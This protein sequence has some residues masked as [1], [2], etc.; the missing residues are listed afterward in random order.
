MIKFI[1]LQEMIKSY[2]LDAKV[3]NFKDTIE[4]DVNGY[5]W[6]LSFYDL[7]TPKC[8]IAHT[9]FIFK[10]DE[11][12][13]NIRKNDFLYLKDLNCVYKIIK[14]EDISNLELIINKI[15][16]ENMFGN[17]IV[18]LSKFL[19]EPE[20]LV[21]NILYDKKIKDK[22]LFTCEYLPNSVVIPCQKLEFN[23]KLNIDGKEEIDML[24]KKENKND[25]EF[26]FDNKYIY[27]QNSISDIANI[28]AEF[29]IKH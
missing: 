15:L 23:F 29:I 8:L 22:S 12:K 20:T 6:V 9:R 11:N 28:V 16:V 13:E 21:N 2:F 5:N 25:F 18:E 10:L 1:E 24:I 17:N 4:K 27:K 26:I 19:T 3:R 14:F 7:R